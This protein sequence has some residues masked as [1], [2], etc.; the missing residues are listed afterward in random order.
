[1]Y[2]IQD[3]M[4]KAADKAAKDPKPAK[5]VELFNAMTNRVIT[6][7]Q[8]NRV[9]YAIAD[10]YRREGK[11]RTDRPIPRDPGKLSHKADADTKKRWHKQAKSY[12]YALD[13]NEDD[14]EF[15]GE[16]VAN[17]G[18]AVELDETEQRW[19]GYIM[20]VDD[21]EAVVESEVPF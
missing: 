4:A 15:I 9:C 1:M 2:G 13:A 7:E 5:Y 18:D 3:A 11:Y 12:R 6:Q 8:M 21:P 16:I 17:M 10:V 20:A 19:V 14:K